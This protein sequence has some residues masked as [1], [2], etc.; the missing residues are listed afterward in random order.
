MFV[1]YFIFCSLFDTVG[2]EK[3]H[4]GGE[5]QQHHTMPDGETTAEQIPSAL[6]LRK[7]TE[8]GWS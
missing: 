6:G 7:G 8:T 2:A 3:S 5:T 1:T 4:V